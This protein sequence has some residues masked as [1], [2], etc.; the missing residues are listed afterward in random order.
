[1]PSPLPPNTKAGVPI[2]A[3]DIEP[4]P[5]PVRP[6]P[7]KLPRPGGAGVCMNTRRLGLPNCRP[8]L[9]FTRSHGCVKL[10]TNVCVGA[11]ERAAAME[12]R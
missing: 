2:G 7:P 4:L 5:L 6:L 12:A 8:S 1:L 3:K 11:G 9:V 10:L